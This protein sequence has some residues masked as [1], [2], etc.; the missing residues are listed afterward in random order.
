MTLLI[1]LLP[2]LIL[3]A[4][5]DDFTPQPKTA[6]Y[7]PSLPGGIAYPSPCP[8]WSHSSTINTD[9]SVYSN[10]GCATNTNLARQLAYP[11]D[12]DHASGSNA[13]GPDTETTTRVLERYRAG[14]IPKELTPVQGATG[15]N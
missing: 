7:D 8:D 9:N 13:T 11:E 1:R 5:A 6:R 12:L 10:Y 3:S 14:E 15:G 4:C 2:L